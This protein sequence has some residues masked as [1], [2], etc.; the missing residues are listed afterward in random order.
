MNKKQVVKVS[1]SGYNTQF[2]GY[3]IVID[4]EK[5]LLEN[6]RVLN[7]KTKELGTIEEPYNAGRYEMISYSR[8]VNAQI[9]ATRN[10]NPDIRTALENG[11]QDFIDLEKIWQKVFALM[12]DMKEV[13][14]NIKQIPDAARQARGLLNE[15]Q[16]AEAFY[17]ALP[18]KIKN[19]MSSNKRDYWNNFK[20]YQ[21]SYDSYRKGVE[22]CLD[23]DIEKYFRKASFIEEEYDGTIFLANNA[24]KDP[25]YK[26]ILAKYSS[27][28]PVSAKP[29]ECLSVG[30]DKDYLVYHC[31]YFIPVKKPLTADYAAELAKSFSKG[32]DKTIER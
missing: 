24:D 21:V 31:S 29:E 22:I 15:G 4:Q 19:A 20:E 17:K 1:Y 2:E 8:Q 3:G 30:G 28:L 23:I 9:S 25:N 13:R 12:Q 14:E 6:E 7:L 11:Y 16:F 10:V 27:K 18:G 26:K 5:I 32:K